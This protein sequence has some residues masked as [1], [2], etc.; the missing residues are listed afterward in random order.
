MFFSNALLQSAQAI[1]SHKAG[2]FNPRVAPGLE[3]IFMERPSHHLTPDDPL[4]ET[5]AALLR[6]L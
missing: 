1:D 6:I 3:N 5:G 4:Q 2:T